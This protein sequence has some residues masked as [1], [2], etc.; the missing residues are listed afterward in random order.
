MWRAGL[1]RYWPGC[2]EAI[3]GPALGELFDRYAGEVH[4]FAFRRT[5][6]WN[7]AEDL[8]QTTFL[9]TWRR[10]QRNHQAC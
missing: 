7:T 8:V 9:N 3:G 6:S 5:A 2:D 1:R 4:A 10:F